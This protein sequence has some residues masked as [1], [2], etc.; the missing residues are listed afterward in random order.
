MSIV[1]S[2]APLALLGLQGCAGIQSAF[3]P[4]GIEAERI[5]V[6][7]WLL[8]LFSTAV[9]VGVCAIAAA[10]LFGG[11]ALRARIS[12]ERLVVGG[13]IIFPVLALSLLLSYGFYLMGPGLPVAHR[14]GGLRIEVEGK[15]WWWRVTYVDQNG[16]RIE[17]ANEI[18]L[19]VGRP[20]EIALTSADVIHSFWVPKLA[21]K[22]DMIPGRSN[23]MTLHVTEPGIS[24]GQC[25]EYCG[26]PHAFMAFLVVAVPE[27]EFVAWLDR[28][29][30]DA[31]PPS[32]GEAV[33]GQTLFQSSGCVACH[34]V[35]GTVAQG[36]IGPDLTHVGSRHSLAAATLENDPA[37]FVRWIRDSQHVKPENLMPSL[38]IFTAREL[39]QLASYLD[40]LR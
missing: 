22:L 27:D 19:P 32:G 34:R 13:G 1:R 23:R 12:G 5:N 29:A 28:E 16:R 37:A 21:G 31:L 6:L 8:I 15:Q 33:I 25:A 24:R 39:A 10:A 11:D 36:T 3:E 38:E 35:R 9:L 26:G 7:S 17:S 30:A 20:V 40:Q 2:I 18:R 4:T 14:D